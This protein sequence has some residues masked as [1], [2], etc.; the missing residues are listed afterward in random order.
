[1]IDERRQ[2]EAAINFA[3]YLR[4]GLLKKE[5]NDMAKKKYIENAEIA[6]LTSKI[7][8][9]YKMGLA[10]AIVYATAQEHGATLIT[11]DPG[12]KGKKGVLYIGPRPFSC[13][14]TP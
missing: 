4:D 11:G 13:E 2:K 9:K 3:A 12:F 6:I 14:T 5:R 1:M 8:Y 10:D 7:K